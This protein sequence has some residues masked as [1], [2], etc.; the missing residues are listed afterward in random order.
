MDAEQI[1]DGVK[2]MQ[3]G[4]KAASKGLFRKPDWDL[5]ASCYERA[6][7]SFKIA[8]SSDQAVQAYIKASDALSKADATHLA[9]KALENAAF[10]LAHDLNQ[11]QRAAELYQRASNY[12][13]TQ[14]SIDRAA[15]QLEKAGRALENVD[16]NASYDMYSKACTI[17]EQEDRGRF[18]VDIFKRAV[19]LLIRNKKYDKAIEMLKRQSIVLQ[20]FTS[21]SH[22]YKANLSILIL[23]FAIGDDVEA[24]KQFSY[25]CGNDAGFAQSEEAQIAQDLLQAYDERDQELLERTVRLQH[26]TFLDNEV[27]KLARLLTVPGEVLSSTT[28]SPRKGNYTN[29]SRK[30]PDTHVPDMRS[31]SH[32]EARAELYSSHTGRSTASPA[33][34]EKDGLSKDFSNLRTDDY[35]SDEDEEGLR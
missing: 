9:G 21:R 10:I 18:A 25:M 4:D 3:Q 8:K 6:A 7:T 20:K 11:P 14:G 24:G 34:D 1:R 22:L 12:F 33:V 31:M 5:A 30:V 2:N 32:A 15:E 26:V 17:Y 16:V 19:S 23:I 35:Y 29:P 28:T 13:M 27:V